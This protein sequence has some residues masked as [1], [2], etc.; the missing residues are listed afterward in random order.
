[1]IRAIQSVTKEYLLSG[2]CNAPHTSPF[3]AQRHCTTILAAGITLAVTYKILT[4]V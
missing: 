1:M 3:I 2:Q 4:K